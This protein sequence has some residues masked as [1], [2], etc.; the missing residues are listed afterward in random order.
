[1]LTEV[2]VAPVLLSEVTA[3]PILSSAER[4]QQV[5]AALQPRTMAG[6]LQG[7]LGLPPATASRSGRTACNILDVKYEPD[8]YCVI[9]YQLA[10]QMVIGALRW[11][12][13]RATPGPGQVIG[14]LGMQIY[15]FPDDPALPGLPGALQPQAMASALAAAL[16]PDQTGAARVLRCRV[17]L[18]RYRIGKRATVRFDLLLRATPEGGIVR[19]TFFGKVYHKPSKAAAVYQEMRLL[20]DVAPVREGQI[21]VARAAA[22]L[23]DIPMV[24][25]EPVAGTPLDLLLQGS[26]G[27]QQAENG[28]ARAARALAALHT[29]RLPNERERPIAAEVKRFGRRAALIESVDGDLGAR[30]GRLATALTT[31]LPSLSVWGA[32][33]S[34]VHG[35]CKPSQFLIDGN[36]VALL[37]F[38]HCGIADPASDVGTFLASLRQTSLMQILKAPG[39]PGQTAGAAV[40]SSRM[41]VLEQRF[42]DEYCAARTLDPGFRLRATWY[43]AA[44]LLRKA[45]RAFARSPRSP[46]PAALSEE[47]WRRLAALPPADVA[48]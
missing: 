4:Y 45:L 2:T 28:I 44:A 26:G 18:L 33:I 3:P 21:N 27:N 12:E 10:G 35:D 11:G 22:F 29:I 38:D 46:V 30:L 43:E 16:P 32:T 8:E 9:L 39:A 41:H 20:A 5:T 6:Y 23:P 24:L 17:T 48:Y 1:M 40:R 36:Q 42:L 37:D 34:L 15:L 14:P 13:E 25:Q 47:A 7:A 31:W 19:R